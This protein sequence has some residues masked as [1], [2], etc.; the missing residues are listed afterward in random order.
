MSS[1]PLAVNPPAAP[2]DPIQQAGQ[3]LTL[4]SLIQGIR[5]SSRRWHLGSSRCSRTKSS[6]SSRPLNRVRW[7]SRIKQQQLKDQAAIGNILWGGARSPAFE[8]R[9]YSCGFRQFGSVN[10]DA[11]TGPR[12]FCLKACSDSSIAGCFA[13][14]KAGF[15]ESTDGDAAEAGERRRDHAG[16]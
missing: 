7:I 6:N 5:F 3:A 15:H 16:Q 8:Q 9:N 1:I 13:Q 12:S 14:R 11:T 10:G 2:I 4:Q